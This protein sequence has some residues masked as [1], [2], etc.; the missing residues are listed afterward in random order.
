VEIKH[1]GI[2]SNEDIDKYKKYRKLIEDN[3]FL[4]LYLSKS[5][6]HKPFAEK[7]RENF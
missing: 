2:F 5:E 7:C 1:T 3:D 6:T 4:Y